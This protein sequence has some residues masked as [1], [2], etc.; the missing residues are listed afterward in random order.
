MTIRISSG[1]ASTLASAG[2]ANN[3]LIAW[4]NQAQNATMTTD[5]GTQVAPPA[6]AVTGSTFDR[7]R[8]TANGSGFAAIQAS[9]SAATSIGFVAVAA[10]NLGSAGAT[11]RPQY[12][13][14]GGSSWTPVSATEVSPTDNQAIAWYF[15]PVSAADWRLY[16]SGLSSGDPV[17]AG[18]VFVGNAFAAP[19]RIYGDYAPPITP[20]NVE[21]QSNVSEGGELLGTSAV[22]RGSAATVTLRHLGPSFLRGATWT[23]FQRHFNEGGGFFWAWRP[24]KY[25][26]VHYAWRTG[27]PAAPRNM[28]ILDLMEVQ[29]Q[30]RFHDDA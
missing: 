10:H 19:R 6:N 12:S 22:R 9:F 27:G 24:T 29:M 28:G 21:L 1:L 20:T 13:T 23:A 30:M 18:V 4:F 3:P 5:L 14:D 2:T 25:G 11:V 26:D 7:W 15:T 16:I 8:A 17:N